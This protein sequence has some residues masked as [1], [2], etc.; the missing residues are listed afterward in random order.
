[1]SQREDQVYKANQTSLELLKQLKDSEDE[2]D[3]LKNYILSL[4][5]QMTV[6]I[7]VKNDDTD[8][9]LAEFINNYP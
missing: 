6:Y 3:S 4:K 8:L 7:P 5:Q 1:M 2:I 9:K